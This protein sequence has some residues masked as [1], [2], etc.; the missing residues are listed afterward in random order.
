MEKQ[1][2]TSGVRRA[3]SDLGFKISD[4]GIE[5]MYPFFSALFVDL[6]NHDVHEVL[7]DKDLLDDATRYI[8]NRQEPFL[9]QNPVLEFLMFEVLIQAT[10]FA[11]DNNKKVIQPFFL[12]VMIKQDQTLSELFR[13]YG[14]DAFRFHKDTFSTEASKKMLKYYLNLMLKNQE[15]YKRGMTL[16]QLHQMMNTIV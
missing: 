11:E 12:W 13:P 14:F 4:D 7:K 10:Y 5:F 3:T 1:E 8:D 9:L 2:F 6:C 15:M 16:T